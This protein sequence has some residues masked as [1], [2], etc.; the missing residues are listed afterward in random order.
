MGS[1]FVMSWCE[2]TRFGGVVAMSMKA[3]AQVSIVVPFERALK[4]VYISTLRLMQSRQLATSYA[5]S[6]AGH[7]LWRDARVGRSNFFVGCFFLGKLRSSAKC[8]V[9][10]EETTD[11][12]QKYEIDRLCSRE[13][14][15]S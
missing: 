10:R 13:Q 3:V 2:S 8:L 12:R 5:G 14:L 11:I 4:A 1:L 6:S 15:V 9:P 7:H